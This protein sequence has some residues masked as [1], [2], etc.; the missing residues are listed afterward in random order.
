[1]CM[2]THIYTYLWDSHHRLIISET[3]HHPTAK[4]DSH[5]NG[6]GA[7]HESRKHVKSNSPLSAH[8]YEEIDNHESPI[9]T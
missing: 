9:M 2:L 8:R 1:M 6:G 5:S 4:V 3:K 7:V